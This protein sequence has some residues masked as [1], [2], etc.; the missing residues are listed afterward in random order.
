MP[1]HAVQLELYRVL[2][3][4]WLAVNSLSAF[5]RVNTKAC[6]WLMN[7]TWWT[8]VSETEMKRSS[9]TVKQFCSGENEG[10]LR[11]LTKKMCFSP[12]DIQWR[13][14]RRCGGCVYQGHCK[15]EAAGT[16]RA[17]PDQSTEAQSIFENTLSEVAQASEV[18]I[19]DMC[20]AVEVLP[21]HVSLYF[22]EG[23][24]SDEAPFEIV[25]V[26]NI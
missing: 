1:R 26:T 19:E 15:S 21:R 5:V 25:N 14:D 18:D 24:P 4:K 9:L 6:V 16:I 3:D 22:S 17:L 11:A 10:S 20:G 13:L 7:E 12:D 2:I 23:L 8:P